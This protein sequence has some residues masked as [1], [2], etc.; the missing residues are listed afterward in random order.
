[1]KGDVFI[2][3][4]NTIASKIKELRNSCSLTQ[5]EFAASLN[6]TQAA[7]SGYER[8]DRT[9]SLDML[10]AISETYNVS[11]DWLCNLTEKKNLSNKLSTY[12]DLIRIIMSINDAPEITI[13]FFLQDNKTTDFFEA[14]YQ[15]LVC[16][17]NDKHMVEFFQE[18][19][20]I[21]SVC[22]KSPSGEKL[23]NIWLK[24]IFERFNFKLEDAHQDYQDTAPLPFN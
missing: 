12:S 7:L 21:R 8:G 18:W 2:M 11:I 19:K 15:S 16:E 6:T 10:I 17:I 20:D 24:D 23:Y 4:N 22:Q 3:E 9:P 5:A 13:D 14:S 1:M